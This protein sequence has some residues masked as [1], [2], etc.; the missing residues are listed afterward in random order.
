[1]IQCSFCYPSYQCW[2]PWWTKFGFSPIQIISCCTQL[3][4]Y[5][6]LLLEVKICN[7]VRRY[8]RDISCFGM[9]FCQFGQHAVQNEMFNFHFRQIWRSSSTSW[10]RSMVTSRILELPLW[11]EQ[12]YVDLAIEV[13]IL[14]LNIFTSHAVFCQLLQ[15]AK[16]P[17]TGKNIQRYSLSNIQTRHSNNQILH[18]NKRYAYHKIL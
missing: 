14:R 16:I 15:Q 7:G 4:I 11:T 2:W 12:R 13:W 3:S 17:M 1:M 9:S 6:T 5:W 18:N 8:Y 10:E